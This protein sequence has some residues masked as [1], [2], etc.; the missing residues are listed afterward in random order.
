MR[1]VAVKKVRII[2]IYVMSLEKN[3]YEMGM[4]IGD[5]PCTP[6]FT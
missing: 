3:Q 4:K 1:D 5:V 2:Q 6:Y